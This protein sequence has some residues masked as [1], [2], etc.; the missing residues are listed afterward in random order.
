MLDLITDRTQAD[1]ENWLTLSLIKWD[2]MTA[3]QKETWSVPMKGAYNFTDLNRVGAAMLTLQALFASCGYTVSVNV[4]ADYAMGERPTPAEMDAYIQS[5][6]NL[7]AVVPVSTASPPDSMNGGTVV[8]W[9]NIERIL[10]A[11]EAAITSLS[12]IFLRA[13]M[14][15][16]VAGNE[17]YITN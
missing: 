13:G 1:F 12:R 5:L 4:R 2:D 16:A 11:V 15:W 6:K 8:I 14:P 17:I 3:E 9:N 10:L 7:K